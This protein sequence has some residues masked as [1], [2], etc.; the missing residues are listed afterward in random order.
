[1]KETTQQVS[2]LCNVPHANIR[3]VALW[4]TS[5]LKPMSQQDLHCFGCYN[6][7]YSV[8]PDKLGQ[9]NLWMK[10]WHPQNIVNKRVQSY[11]GIINTQMQYTKQCCTNNASF[12]YTIKTNQ[13][14]IIG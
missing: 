14:S 7:T 12:N 1:M 10:Q 4:M 9:P 6:S 3:G 5:N 11:K 8:V 2:E 13:D